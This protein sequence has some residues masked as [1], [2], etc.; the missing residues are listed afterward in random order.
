MPDGEPHVRVGDS[1]YALQGILRSSKDN[2]F[3]GLKPGPGVRLNR[4][5][6]FKNNSYRESPRRYEARNQ[7]L[8]FASGQ[9]I[10]MGSL[11]S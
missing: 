7:R 11:D 6:T 1:S 9:N 5:S 4:V 10:I 2:R 8:N 3:S